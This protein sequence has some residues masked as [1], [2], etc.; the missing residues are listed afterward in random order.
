[1]ADSNKF[2]IDIA[3]KSLYYQQK[4]FQKK[5]IENIGYYEGSSEDL[6]ELP[7]DNIEAC[8]YHMLALLEEA[9]ELVKSD[10]RWKNY[11][12]KKYDKVNKLEELADCFITL[13]NIALFSGIT[14]DELTK[15]I[16][17]KIDKN[18][19]RLISK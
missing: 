6:Q 7:V 3:M 9:G 12:N 18:N 17:D 14:Y 1:M 11:R 13:T 4:D 2:V 8:K 10:K 5:V 16:F 15:A 19:K